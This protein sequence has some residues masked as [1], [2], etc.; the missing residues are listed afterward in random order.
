MGRYLVGKRDRITRTDTYLVRVDSY[1][2]RV[3]EDLEP[4][5]LFPF[6]APN[7]FVTLMAK[8]E[9]EVALIH[10]LDE[11]DEASRRAVE[12]CFDEYYLIPAVTAVLHVEDK[13]GSF[14]WRVM[15]DRGEV[16]FH[17]RNRQSDIKQ[18]GN[19]LLMRDSNDNRYRI[20]LEKLDSKSMKRILSYI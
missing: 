11:L 6:T 7:S 8:G 3:Y 12:E 5:R 16:E 18:D 2:G 9:K 15:T 10:S 17:I 13:A 20:D 14:K 19:V 4:R 1:D